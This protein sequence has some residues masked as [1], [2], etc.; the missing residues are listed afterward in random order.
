MS[1]GR[2]PVRVG[3]TGSIGA[4][5]STVARMLAARGA[6]VV[7]ADVLARQATEDPDVL[8]AI[9]RELGEDLVVPGEAG[10]TLDRAATAARVFDDPEALARLNGIVH[11]WVRRRAAERMDALERSPSPPPAI[12]HDVPLL[13]E[14]GL[15]GDY[16][17]VVVVD[18]PPEER[19]RRLARRSGLGPQEVARRES[20][21]MPAHEK[22]ARADHVVVNAGDLHELE[23][24]V[25]RLWRE[26]TRLR[27]R[28]LRS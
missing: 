19:A 24:Q 15:E 26:L 20:A 14:S 4:G 17:L 12:V 11:P 5:K 9:A 1:E 23:A 21:Q 18:A 25:S 3:L 13:F 10:P 2:R 27:T 7:D 28:T 22:A 6:A 8:A 16:D